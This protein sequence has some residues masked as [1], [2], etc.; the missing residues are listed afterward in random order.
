MVTSA[1][2]KELEKMLAEDDL[3][4]EDMGLWLKA[5]EVTALMAIVDVLTALVSVTA[6][7]EPE[8]S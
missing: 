8:E 4:N 3:S 5:Q 6:G 7:V 2:Q 1:F